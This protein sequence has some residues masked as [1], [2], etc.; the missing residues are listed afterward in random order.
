MQFD[1]KAADYYVGRSALLA[2]GL[3]ITYLIERVLYG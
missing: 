1:T 2:L 3:V